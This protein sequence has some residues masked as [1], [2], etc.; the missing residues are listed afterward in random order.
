MNMASRDTEHRLSTFR[1]IPKN[2]SHSDTKTKYLQGKEIRLKPILSKTLE[3]FCG[4]QHDPRNCL[5]T[6]A[7]SRHS[8]PSNQGYRTQEHM[9]ENSEV[10]SCWKEGRKVKDSEATV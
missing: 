3:R 1:H 9:K 5:S 2:V 4:K 7:R 6:K 10:Q 8:Q